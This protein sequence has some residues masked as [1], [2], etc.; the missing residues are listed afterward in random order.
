MG[1]RPHWWL[2]KTQVHLL[3]VVKPP[4]MF[5]RI[6]LNSEFQCF[7]I[8][9]CWGFYCTFRANAIGY[10]FKKSLPTWPFSKETC[11]YAKANILRL[12]FMT[13]C[14]LYSCEHINVSFLRASR[15]IWQSIRANT[16]CSQ[17][18]AF[19][20]EDFLPFSKTCG[21]RE[22]FCL[23]W[24]KITCSCSDFLKYI[25][26]N[27]NPTVTVTCFS[28]DAKYLDHQSMTDSADSS[29]TVRLLRL[30]ERLMLFDLLLWV[31]RKV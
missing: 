9:R 22:S 1:A 25:F 5:R 24:N 31:L 13:W 28:T 4:L 14:H 10:F 7:L 23:A 11:K 15:L 20:W 8:N 27:K 18:F 29:A 30:V 19:T 3:T 17:R 6:S 21:S 12:L 26:S 16:S 2:H